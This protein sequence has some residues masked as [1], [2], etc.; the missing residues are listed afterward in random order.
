MRSDRVAVTVFRCFLALLMVQAGVVRA[1]AAGQ[2][3]QMPQMPSM[4]VP[5]PSPAPTP[6]GQSNGAQGAG[7]VGGWCAQGDPTKQTS[8]SYNGVMYNLTNETGSS[9]IGN[10]QG[11]NQIV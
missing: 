2:M 11:N 1:E 3:P 9:S 8:I 7:F 6:A 10:L 4:P 5:N